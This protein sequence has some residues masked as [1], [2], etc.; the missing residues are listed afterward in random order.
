MTDTPWLALKGELWGVCCGYLRETW[1]R[2][3]ESSMLT[4]RKWS[5]VSI[6][7]TNFT[8]TAE[9]ITVHCPCPLNLCLPLT[10]F[11]ILRGHVDVKAD[12]LG[13]TKS[14]SWTRAKHRHKLQFPRASTRALQ[15]FFIKQTPSISGRVKHSGW[16]PLI[17]ATPGWSN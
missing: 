1:P 11:K 7:Q 10:T 6:T 2:D 16:L 5:S 15:H 12:T 3:S 13:L 14:D 8:E 17:R 4:D 9:D